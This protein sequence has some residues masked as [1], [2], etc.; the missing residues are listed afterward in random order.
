MG[1]LRRKPRGSPAGG[2]FAAAPVPDS[3]ADPSLGLT[4]DDLADARRLLRRVEL[5]ARMD[6]RDRREAMALIAARQ[7]AAAAAAA[8][9]LGAPRI[10]TAPAPL[11]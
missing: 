3:A 6:R 2:Q 10:V 9:A 8:S 1:L 7:Q 5:V 11:L 4:G